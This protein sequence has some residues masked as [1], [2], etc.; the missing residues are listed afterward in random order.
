M[1]AVK[2]IPHATKAVV[3]VHIGSKAIEWFRGKT[4]LLIIGTIHA[5]DASQR[6]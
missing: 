5:R 6:I 2:N 1:K 3:D 4:L